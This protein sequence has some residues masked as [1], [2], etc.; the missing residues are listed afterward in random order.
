MHFEGKWPM[1]LGPQS[2]TI[3]NIS[4]FLSVKQSIR[5][6]VAKIVKFATIAATINI[7][8]HITHFLRF[9]RT[10]T[11]KWMKSALLSAWRGVNN[12]RGMISY[13]LLSLLDAKYRSVY[14]IV[15]KKKL[16]FT[17]TSHFWNA[18]LRLWSTYAY[19]PENSKEGECTYL[20]TLIKD[21]SWMIK[22]IAEMQ[23][24]NETGCRFAKGQ[25]YR[26]NRLILKG[27]QIEGHTTT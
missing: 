17:A 1:I 19:Y 7:I 24:R 12:T 21:L 16:K 5:L 10:E 3:T 22:V 23:E 11:I 26:Q 4:L 27:L 20:N 25:Y 18:Y 14:V 8:N 9:G 6:S 13:L 15:Q 2:S